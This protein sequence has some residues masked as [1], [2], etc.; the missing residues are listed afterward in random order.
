MTRQGVKNVVSAHVCGLCY[1]HLSP[2]LYHGFVFRS[3]IASYHIGK[4][5]SRVDLQ[6][7]FF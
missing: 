1:R 6:V 4:L 2:W 3:F 7:A 5:H